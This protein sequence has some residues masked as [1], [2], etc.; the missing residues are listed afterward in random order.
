MGDYTLDAAIAH[1][2]TEDIMT[3]INNMELSTA[4]PVKPFL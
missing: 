4:T 3:Q 1:V 2:A